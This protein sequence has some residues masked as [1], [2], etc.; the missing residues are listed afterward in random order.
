M[1]KSFLQ[2]AK[3]YETKRGINPV[4]AARD[5]WVRKACLRI[6]RQFQRAYA[7]ALLAWKG[8]DR[9]VAFPF[10]TWWMLVHHRAE[11]LPAPR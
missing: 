6:Q 8:G 11:V 4:L 7:E 2:R 3:S 5:V 10:G 1:S 9:L